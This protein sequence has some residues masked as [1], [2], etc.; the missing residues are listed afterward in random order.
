MDFSMGNF[1]VDIVVFA[2][3]AGFLILRLRSVLGKKTGFEKKNNVDAVT[4]PQRKTSTNEAAKVLEETPRVEQNVPAIDTDIGQILS[5]ITQLDASF[6]PKKFLD[7]VAVVFPKI[8]SAFASEDLETLKSLLVLDAYRVFEANINERKKLNHVLTAE[9]KSLHSLTIIGASLFEESAIA[10]ATLEVKII[11][12]QI[13]CVY[14]SAKEPIVGTESVT[15]FIDFWTFE[16]V[17][18]IN[19]QGPSWRLKSTRSGR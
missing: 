16:R 18:G 8:L 17:L 5:K 3:L 10:R 11:S 6:D 12:N 9:V 15:E 14:N 7:G 13:N 19:N 2:L 1:P 4:P